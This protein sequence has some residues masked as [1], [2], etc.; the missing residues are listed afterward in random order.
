[1]GSGEICKV[2]DFGLLR[3]LED[4]VEYYVQTSRA[5]C[6]IRWMAPESVADKVFS[7]ASDVW[8]FGILTWE[9]FNPDLVPY[10]EFDNFQ[11]VA[12]QLCPDI[13]MNCPENIGR[14]MNSC[15]RRSP[16]N[17]PSF[18]L[19]VKVLTEINFGFISE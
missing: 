19:I 15:W 5:K 7:H 1:M 10:N 14:L 4:D 16:T 11:V 18:M 9:M 2:S 13:P 3:Q 12:K 6:P 17:R 8:S